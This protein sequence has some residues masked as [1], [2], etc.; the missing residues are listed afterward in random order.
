MGE[1]A[2]KDHLRSLSTDNRHKSKQEELFDRAEVL[3]NGPFHAPSAPLT[4]EGRPPTQ[5]SRSAF[6]GDGVDLSTTSTD[7][8]GSFVLN[9]TGSIL[10]V[11]S[12]EPDSRKRPR[13]S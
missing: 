4:A 3:D 13:K 11:T 7:P 1:K 5:E 10:Q 12:M 2:S 8:F 9:S 6:F